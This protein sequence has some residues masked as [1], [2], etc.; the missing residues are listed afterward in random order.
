MILE[1]SYAILIGIMKGLGTINMAVLWTFIGFFCLGLPLAFFFDFYA[2]ELL[3]L[4]NVHYL[5]KITGLI[6]LYV[7]LSLALILTNL[8]I[9]VEILSVNWIETG[10]QLFAD[11][12]RGN[13]NLFSPYQQSILNQNSS[14]K[15]AQRQFL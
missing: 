11:Y 6:G 15:G 8:C 5:N 4:R 12:F 14:L 10:K 7:G 1:T 13:N 9:F 3:N 2:Q